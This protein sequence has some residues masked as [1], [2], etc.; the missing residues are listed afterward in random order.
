V[1]SIFALKSSQILG[2]GDIA[3]VPKGIFSGFF[4]EFTSAVLYY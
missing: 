4:D 3:S 1:N 2:F